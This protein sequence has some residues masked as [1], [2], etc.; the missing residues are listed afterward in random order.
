MGLL[1]RFKQMAKG[2]VK[3][4]MVGGYRVM[5]PILPVQKNMVIFDSSIGLNY[6]GNP[7][8]VYERMVERGLDQKFRC[9]W[10]F[11]KGKE[12]R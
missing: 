2:A 6:T 9:I 12:P 5:L 1:G 3:T 4:L 7:R 11:Q 10:L 8:A